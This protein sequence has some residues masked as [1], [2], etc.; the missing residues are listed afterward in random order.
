[1]AMDSRMAS[2]HSAATQVARLLG[3]TPE[4]LAGCPHDYPASGW[5]TLGRMFLWDS[6]GYATTWPESTVDAEGRGVLRPFATY[7]TGVRRI[8]LP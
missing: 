8:A 2:V 1:M 4:R 5:D 6:V 3:M 7:R